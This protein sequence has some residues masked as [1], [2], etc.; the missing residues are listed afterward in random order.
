MN[1][2]KCPCG[3]I[4][5]PVK[6]EPQNAI[7]PGTAFEDLPEDWIC[8]RCGYEKEYFKELFEKDNAG[9]I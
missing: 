5:D 8:P 2:F 1:R 7:P 4:Y 9:T 3:Y 6:G